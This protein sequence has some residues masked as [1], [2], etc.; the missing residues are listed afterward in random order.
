MAVVARCV[1]LMAAFWALIG[2]AGRGHPVHEY[3]VTSRLRRR[4]PESTKIVEH[5]CVLT[6]TSC[7]RNVRRGEHFKSTPQH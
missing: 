2:M 6:Q 3:G 7:G 5:F 4:L 1:A